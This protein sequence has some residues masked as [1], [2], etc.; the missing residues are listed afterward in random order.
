MGWL[1]E[2]GPVFREFFFWVSL[3]AE[4]PTGTAESAEIAF[5]VVLLGLCLQRHSCWRA[6]C[7][8]GFGSE[9]TSLYWR[10]PVSSTK[11]AWRLLEL[12]FRSSVALLS[13]SMRSSSCGLHP[14]RPKF[15]SRVRW[16]TKCPPIDA[17][18]L[19]LAYRFPYKF[20]HQ[21]LG[22]LSVELL[23]ICNVCGLKSCLQPAAWYRLRQIGSVVAEQSCAC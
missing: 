5:A 14:A 21:A 19:R 7:S 2:P 20:G 16:T 4:V 18:R 9:Q 1:L 11:T 6:N 10:K 22:S 23:R 13:S 8:Y 3:R 17:L 12:P 15:P